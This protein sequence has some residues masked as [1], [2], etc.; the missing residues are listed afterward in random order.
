MEKFKIVCIQKGSDLRPP[1]DYEVEKA[2]EA[3]VAAGW[4]FVQ[5]ATG[6]AG[7]SGP[8]ATSS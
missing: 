4:Q 6:G 3:G 8:T 7:S 5:I 1:T 2:I